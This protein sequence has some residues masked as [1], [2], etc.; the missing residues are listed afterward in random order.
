V[1]R[2]PASHRHPS[3]IATF[4]TREALFRGPSTGAEAT[5]LGEL[6]DRL[7]PRGRARSRRCANG[8]PTPTSSWSTTKKGMIE[9][10]QLVAT[11]AP[12]SFGR[13][14]VRAR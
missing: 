1:A 3:L 11:R 14:F 13:L 9:A 10:L 5:K 2:R 12:A 6:A 8:L 4:P 7:D